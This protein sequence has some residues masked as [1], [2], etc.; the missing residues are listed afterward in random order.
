MARIPGFSEKTSVLP[1]EQPVASVPRIPG[2]GEEAITSQALTKVGDIAL[3]IAQARKG[4]N[5]RTYALKRHNE[6]LDAISKFVEQWDRDAKEE[7]FVSGK[8]H[9]GID[10][11]VRSRFE[12]GQ[13]NAPSETS[14]QMYQ[15]FMNEYVNR[16]SATARSSQNTMRAALEVRSFTEDSD[17]FARRMLDRP[18]RLAAKTFIGNTSLAIQ[19]SV[20]STLTNEQGN[21]IRQ[22][23]R[24]GVALNY[25]NGL[26]IA[27]LSKRGLSELEEG[28]GSLSSY[29]T[30]S[31]KESL[32]EAFERGKKSDDKFKRRNMLYN[33]Q[34]YD[35]R[36]RAGDSP[37]SLTQLHTEVVR[38]L[39][40]CLSAEQCDSNE[41][42]RL[43]T[44]YVTLPAIGQILFKTL[45]SIPHEAKERYKKFMTSPEFV[46]GVLNHAKE[47]KFGEL[48][49]PGFAR[50]LIIDELND[51]ESKMKAE[52][53]KYA[54]D[55]TGF[56]VD[57]VDGSVDFLAKAA[58]GMPA[59]TSEVLKSDPPIS[60]NPNK[61]YKDFRKNPNRNTWNAYRQHLAP[62]MRKSGISNWRNR[63]LRRSDL[64]SFAA[65]LLMSDDQ[66]KLEV[67]KGMESKAALNSFRQEAIYGDDFPNIIAQMV[68]DPDIK[69]NPAYSL[70]PFVGSVD[71]REALF[72]HISNS[73]D[74]FK[75]L[76][77]K[78]SEIFG[79]TNEIYK[80][81]KSE[82]TDEYQALSMMAGDLGGFELANRVEG[83]VATA[84]VMAKTSDP[85]ISN[86]DAIK[87][88]KSVIIGSAFHEP[89][90]VNNFK[91]MVPR[92]IR[93][94]GINLDNVKD[95]VESAENAVD[96]YK[97]NIALPD[98]TIVTAR[99][100]QNRRRALFSS[101]AAKSSF[102][103]L[104][105]DGKRLVLK[106][107][108]S[109]IGGIT[110]KVAL[111]EDGTEIS[112]PL[113]RISDYGKKLLSYDKK[114]LVDAGF[115]DV[116]AIPDTRINSERLK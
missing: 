57:H 108:T 4:Q 92:S 90:D 9:E 37:E 50:G 91:L 112:Y 30:P 11:F 70:L 67:P 115:F 31:Q 102:W 79:L 49:D 10:S 63:L 60:T 68:E 103:A 26:K 7:D 19:D 46:E 85:G 18:D 48:V 100:D 61:A 88:G 25:F 2:G 12:E 94:K 58:G 62:A 56:I 98:V 80:S 69:L 101:K 81:T 93:N 34:D 23:M 51:L 55:P 105:S 73:K 38:N 5:D 28:E 76:K 22:G 14:K 33:L 8:Y 66:Y 72:N 74:V 13:V 1:L 59:L 107:S 29:L 27:G 89:I 99:L 52:A 77:D 71:A 41:V 82:M 43:Y 95:F 109:A 45:P 104:S 54:G 111:R 24:N 113:S 87:R 116:M 114:N 36:V 83:L 6:D 78:D 39:S 65:S 96:L 44:K 106:L 110:S 84:A 97:L 3:K 47:G 21:K 32:I 20:G 17:S 75:A 15:S 40:E 53:S 16:V 35:K 64:R 42:N 86:D